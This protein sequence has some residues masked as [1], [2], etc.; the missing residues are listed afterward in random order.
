MRFTL[1][2]AVRNHRILWK[3]IAKLLEE[4]DYSAELV[5]KKAM[6]NKFPAE[7]VNIIHNN[8]FLCSYTDQFSGSCSLCPLQNDEASS[9]LNGLWSLFYHSNS[10]G[11]IALEI[12][13]LPIVNWKGE[14]LENEKNR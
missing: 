5:K 1:E 13:E 12:A 11:K 10:P 3:E 7:L 4:G 9:C 14:E 8:C 6:E 2:E